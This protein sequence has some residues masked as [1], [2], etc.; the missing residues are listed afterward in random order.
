MS[1]DPSTD[2][3]DGAASVSSPFTMTDV[4]VHE[5]DTLWSGFFHIERLQ[6]SH[7]LYGGGWSRPVSRELFARGNAVGVLLVDTKRQQ[8]V[9]TEQF[10]VGALRLQDSPERQSSPERG[11]SPEPP[12]PGPWLLELV[13]GMVEPGESP[14][15][16]AR[17]ETLEETGLTIDHVTPITAYYSSPGGSDEWISLFWASVDASAAGGVHGCVDESEDIRTVIMSLGEAEQALHSG[18]FANAMTVIAM[19][20]LLLNRNRVFV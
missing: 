8:L 3:C 5:R 19:Q 6:L 13:A 11:A 10:R 15:D 1:R 9:L 20:W 7:R 17:R 12:A 16:V 18:S 2:S 14:A 4:R